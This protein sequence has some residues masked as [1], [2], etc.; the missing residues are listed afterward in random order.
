MGGLPPDATYSPDD[1][2]SAR[3]DI[4]VSFFQMDLPEKA[5]QAPSAPV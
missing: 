5:K 3:L 2:P 4:E 1:T